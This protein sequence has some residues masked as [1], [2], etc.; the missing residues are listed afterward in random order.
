MRRRP[1]AMRGMGHPHRGWLCFTLGLG[2]AAVAAPVPVEFAGVDA[3]ADPVL[4]S[5][6]NPAT[7]EREWVK[8]GG[9]FAGC[10]VRAYDAKKQTLRLARGEEIW[11]VALQAASL[12]RRP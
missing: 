5:L 6:V 1:Y 10:E 12:P 7:K 11:E 9:H 8:L 3:S 4:V 2:S